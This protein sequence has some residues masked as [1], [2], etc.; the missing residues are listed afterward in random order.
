MSSATLLLGLLIAFL[1][2]TAFHFWRGGNG[3]RWLIYL[4][5]SLVGFWV[6]HFLAARQ[7]WNFLEIGFLKLGGA[8]V[9]SALFLLVGHWL[10][11]KQRKVI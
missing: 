11:Q 5:L 2:G 7:G 10:G 4:L 1:Y 9:G 6:G 8:T 3:W